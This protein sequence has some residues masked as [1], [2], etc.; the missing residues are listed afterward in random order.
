MVEWRPLK[1][2]YEEK[3]SYM[4][5]MKSKDRFGLDLSLGYNSIFLDSWPQHFNKWVSMTCDFSYK[6]VSWRMTFLQASFINLYILNKKWSI[7]MD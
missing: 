1:P 3:L 7:Q 6:W 5:D 4:W 2:S